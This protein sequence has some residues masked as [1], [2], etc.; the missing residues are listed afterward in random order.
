MIRVGAK[1]CHV[2]CILGCEP[3]ERI[4][5]RDVYF[6]VEY[7]LVSPSLD[8]L[9]QSVDYVS[10]VTCIATMLKEHQYRIIEYAVQDILQSLLANFPKI[11]QV[12]VTV[13]KPSPT[14]DIQETYASMSLNRHRE[15]RSI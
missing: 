8:D 1:K 9:S 13:Y 10:V 4:I 14:L 11:E 6:D 5:I 3:Q 7:S 2:Q 12:S 15:D